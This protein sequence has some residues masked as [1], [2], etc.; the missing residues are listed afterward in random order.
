MR[1]PHKAVT[2]ADLRGFD[3][4]MYVVHREQFDALYDLVM[5]HDPAQISRGKI[6]PR[7]D[8]PGHT[9]E[10]Y[11]LSQAI[12]AELYRRFPDNADIRDSMVVLRREPPY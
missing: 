11:Q 2:H 6:F 4:D 5:E 12:A 9:P 8:G 7:T 10:L 3:V 1:G